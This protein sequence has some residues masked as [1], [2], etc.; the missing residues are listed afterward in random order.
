MKFAHP[1]SS[2][3]VASANLLLLA[4]AGSPAPA[5]P[6]GQQPSSSAR[7]EGVAAVVESRA[8]GGR[9]VGGVEDFERDGPKNATA[10]SIDRVPTEPQQQQQT[11]WRDFLSSSATTAS[12]T[13]Q[14]PGPVCGT[15]EGTA[16]WDDLSEER[17][18]YYASVGWTQQRWDRDAPQGREI[19]YQEFNPR[20]I[21]LKVLALEDVGFDLLGELLASH[22]AMLRGGTFVGDDELPPRDY[23]P[24]KDF[25][26]EIRTGS[27]QHYLKYDAED[28]SWKESIQKGLGIGILD[29]LLKALDGVDMLPGKPCGGYAPGYAWTFWVGAAG[30]ITGMH[31]DDDDYGFLYVTSGRKRIVVIPND[32]RTLNYT[33]E[34]YIQDHSCW[35]GIDVLNGPL[36]P[37]AV[38]FEIGPGEGIFIPSL[39]WHAVMNLEPTIAF[40]IFL[41]END[42]C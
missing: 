15:V 28:E 23:M 24:M 30:T 7:K 17:Q 20:T 9:A 22:Q 29:S 32:E 3:V 12:F 6:L 2:F 40:G 31:Y 18:A 34:T 39:A 8:G 4:L 33:C 37:H 16:S 10:D 1:T 42:F 25:L 13:L 14:P 35:T 36:P 26:E 11:L 41:N 27:T 38:E 21:R 19:S 5:A